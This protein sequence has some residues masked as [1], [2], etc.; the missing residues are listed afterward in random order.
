M[1][2]KV[3]LTK[4]WTFGVKSRIER[5]KLLIQELELDIRIK[6]LKGELKEENAKN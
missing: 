6:K 1:T 3:N 4:L 2:D 5:K